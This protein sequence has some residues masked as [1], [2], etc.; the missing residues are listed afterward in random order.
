M[1]CMHRGVV[2]LH[3]VQCCSLKYWTTF[4]G[5]KKDRLKLIKIVLSRVSIQWRNATRILC[6]NKTVLERRLW[7]ER[8]QSYPKF[9]SSSEYP[10]WLQGSQ[11]RIKSVRDRRKALPCALSR[12]QREVCRCNSS[13]GTTWFCWLLNCNVLNTLLSEWNFLNEHHLELIST[14]R[15]RAAS[16]VLVKKYPEEASR[17]EMITYENLSLDLEFWSIGSANSCSKL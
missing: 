14:H 15:Y 3:V 2:E 13:S 8:E 4:L 6:I 5:E 7:N 10:C 17:L 1:N 16:N 12:G 11:R 9:S